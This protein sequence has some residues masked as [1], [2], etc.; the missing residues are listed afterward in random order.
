[1]QLTF[2]ADAVQKCQSF[3]SEITV[4]NERFVCSLKMIKY[5]NRR[6]HTKTKQRE[7]L[8]GLKQA[9]Q[10]KSRNSKRK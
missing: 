5:Q 6:S 4:N 2:F 9:A 8:R 1:M 10:M 7:L 3:A